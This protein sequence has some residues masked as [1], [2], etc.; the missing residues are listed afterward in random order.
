MKF[1]DLSKR[2][3]FV[4]S[5]SLPVWRQI[6][7]LEPDNPQNKQKCLFPH[8]YQQWLILN[9]S[10]IK[11]QTC[12]LSYM[13]QGADLTKRGRMCVA[14]YGSLKQCCQLLRVLFFHPKADLAGRSS[15]RASE[16][17]HNSKQQQESS[18]PSQLHSFLL[19]EGNRIEK[20]NCEGM[21]LSAFMTIKSF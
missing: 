2:R 9:I 6:K 5:F 3:I 20:H 19:R 11:E 16:V 1:P 14:Y 8:S 10:N 4:F 13:N 17:L 12:C 21:W 15:G 7:C 18:V